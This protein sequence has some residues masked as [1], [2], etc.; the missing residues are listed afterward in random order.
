MKSVYVFSLVLVLSCHQGK[1]DKTASQK[2]TFEKSI[3]PKVNHVNSE[4]VGSI[5]DGSIG[6][7]S[8]TDNITEK[9]TIKL[10]NKDGSLWYE[11]SF[12]Y[13]DS[14]GKFDY[15]NDDFKPLAFH[16]DNFLLML[17]VTNRS[18]N[19]YE[20][21]VNEKTVFKKYLEKN[22]DFF[23]FQSWEE[24]ILKIP[25]VDFNETT[26]PILEKPSKNAGKIYYGK[27]ELY[28][29]NKINGEWLQLKWGSEGD[30]EYGW[31]R[32]RDNEKLLIE[33]YYLT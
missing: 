9:D 33:L 21:I 10:F 17:K 18:G 16:P 3:E 4:L 11:F 23:L 6:I 5:V 7:V 24:H 14:D 13:D 25:S 29:P 12:F 28:Q 30:W 8:V 22:Q 27:D 2:N 15:P 26:N 20:V 19:R 31:I 32:W 1:S